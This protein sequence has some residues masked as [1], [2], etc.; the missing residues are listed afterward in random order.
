MIDAI[1]ESLLI[2]YYRV[3]FMSVSKSIELQAP[4]NSGFGIQKNTSVVCFRRKYVSCY[5]TRLITFNTGFDIFLGLKEL[6][7][8]RC[9]PTNTSLVELGRKSNQ[10]PVS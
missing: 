8:Q 5:K 4:S 9:N 7:N 1:S 3:Q 2:T 10:L 6:I